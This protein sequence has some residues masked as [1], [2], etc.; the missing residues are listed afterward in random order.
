MNKSAFLAVSIWAT[1]LGSASALVV[2]VR[3][4]HVVAVPITGLIDPPRML[5]DP[6]P[7]PLAVESTIEVSPVVVTIAAPRR[8][9][10]PRDLAQMRCGPWQGMVQGPETAEVRRCD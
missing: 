7:P 2:A 1:G 9:A 3:R 5:A 6:P 4:P 8:R 10:L